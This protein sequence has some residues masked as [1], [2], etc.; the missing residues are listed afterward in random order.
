MDRSELVF[1]IPAKNEEKTIENVILTVSKYGNVIVINDASTDSTSSIIKKFDVNL[2]NNINNIGYQNSILKGIKEAIKLNYKFAITFDADNQHLEENIK[3]FLEKFE[4]DYDFVIGE[5]SFFNR[6]SE[7]ILSIYSKFFLE[8]KDILSGMKG[9]NLE[10]IKYENLI[11]KKNTFCAELAYI[12]IKN[13]Y[14][15]INIPIKIK[16]RID[17][18]RLGNE[19]VV[20]F[21]I[22]Y[23]IMY[24]LYKISIKRFYHEFKK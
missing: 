13:K 19:L 23:I 16:N 4:L 15:V 3:L 18:P 14:R 6:F 12:L 5:R 2:I 21:K 7:K 24:L 10:S 11:F 20:N 8:S 1:I 22:I 17:K 9:Y